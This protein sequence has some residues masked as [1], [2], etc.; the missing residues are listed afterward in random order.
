M[1]CWLLENAID[2]IGGDGNSENQI[3]NSMVVFSSHTNTEQINNIFQ[4]QLMYF[5]YLVINLKS[6]LIS[7]PMMNMLDILPKEF[8]LASQYDAVARSKKYVF[9]YI[10]I[11]HT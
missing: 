9:T 5:R 11:I 3:E 1:V 7:L 6:V 2:E 4:H 8:V 10:Y